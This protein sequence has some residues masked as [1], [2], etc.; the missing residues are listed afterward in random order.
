M[1]DYR[2]EYR[3][4][5]DG[6]ECYH[7]DDADKCRAKLAELR[8]RYPRKEFT[9]QYRIVRLDRYGIAYRDY[10]GRPQWSP[11]RTA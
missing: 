7:T 8:A 6:C 9:R 3:I 2:C 11:W 5:K 4:N 1:I 10:K